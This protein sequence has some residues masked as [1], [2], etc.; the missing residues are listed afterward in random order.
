[1][2]ALYQSIIE[3]LVLPKKTKT[4]DGVKNMRNR[5][6]SAFHITKKE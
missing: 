4:K 1:M 3:F 5:F 2:A 6:D